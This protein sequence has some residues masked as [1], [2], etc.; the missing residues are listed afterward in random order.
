MPRALGGADGSGDVL[1]RQFGLI[2][3]SDGNTVGIAMAVSQ[4][5]KDPAIGRDAITELSAQVRLR[6]TGFAAP[7]CS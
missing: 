6:A 5:S 4:A 2:R 1:V 7:N 3:L